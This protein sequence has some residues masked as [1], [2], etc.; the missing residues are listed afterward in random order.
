MTGPAIVPELHR[1]VATD[2]IPVAGMTLEVV[3]DAAECAAVAQR[4]GVPA[5]GGLS[6]RFTLHR[7]LAGS[8]RR[9]EGEI[10]ADAV[11]RA[12]LVRECV[13]TL[14]P[15]ET[16]H[17]EA[18]RVRFVPAGTESE[19]DDPE[20]CDEIGYEGAAIDLGDAAVEQLALTLDPYPRSP[21]AA[22]PPEASD[23]E[24]NAFSALVRLMPPGTA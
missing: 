3:A 8:T 4:L 11:L 15:F 2:R 19:D 20:A 16:V 9:R 17:A 5:V 21:G 6:C 1:P 13:V 22:L 23:P 18:F 7:P 10:V 12:T 14:E 24:E